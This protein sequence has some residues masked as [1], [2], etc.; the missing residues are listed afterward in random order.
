MR[1]RSLW[2]TRAAV[3]LGL[4]ALTLSF[5]ASGETSEERLNRFK[6]F[7]ECRPMDLAVEHL[8]SGAAEIGSGAGF[9]GLPRPR[10]GSCCCMA[11]SCS[12]FLLGYR[13]PERQRRGELRDYVNPRRTR[14]R[15]LPLPHN[16]V[17]LSEEDL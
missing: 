12:L 8:P 17:T 1:D 11:V 13:R 5:P 14:R 3:V 9:G 2:Q 10:F 7:A 6:L 4:V 16:S 15:E